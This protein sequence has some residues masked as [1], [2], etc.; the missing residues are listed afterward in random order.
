MDDQRDLLA[1]T[2]KPFVSRPW[3]PR[4]SA[5]IV[6]PRPVAFLLFAF[7][8]ILVYACLQMK[9]DP[10]RWLV[11]C[12][13][14]GVAAGGVGILLQPRLPRGSSVPSARRVIKVHFD[15]RSIEFRYAPIA[16]SF[17]KTEVAEYYECPVDDLRA[18]S[19][20]A[21]RGAATLKLW[22]PR[23]QVMINSNYDP[24]LKALYQAIQT[25]AG[26]RPPP[27]AVSGTWVS[28]M[29]RYFSSRPRSC[30]PADDA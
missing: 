16:T 9:G 30:W 12:V 26:N 28:L 19:F 8:G 24:R 20:T 18:Y 14:A 5:A 27:L 7:A 29:L 15:R 13:G 25:L 3:Q 6:A 23:G 4:S 11:L 22:T 21:F 10:M 1:H 2:R 17:T